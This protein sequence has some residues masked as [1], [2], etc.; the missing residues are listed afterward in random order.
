MKL[1]Q[2]LGLATLAIAFLLGLFV[3]AGEAQYRSRWQNDNG[4][5]RGWNW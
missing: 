1:L 4:R 3:A 2:K 5:H